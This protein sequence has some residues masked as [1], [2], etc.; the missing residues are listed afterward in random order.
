MDKLRKALNVRLSEKPSEPIEVKPSSN[1]NTFAAVV[2]DSTHHPQMSKSLEDVSS[3][4]LQSNMLHSFGSKVRSIS[5]DETDINTGKASGV[6]S[7]V[8]IEPELASLSNLDPRRKRASPRSRSNSLNAG[9][10]TGSYTGSGFSARISGK[11]R[12]IDECSEGSISPRALPSPYSAPE[13]VAEGSQA[14]SD[15]GF[16][17]LRAVAP[18]PSTA[19]FF[20]T[21]EE[22]NVHTAKKSNT[23]LDRGFSMPSSQ[24]SLPIY[25]QPESTSD[26]LDGICVESDE[27][28]ESRDIEREGIFESEGTPI[29]C[30][31]NVIAMYLIMCFHIC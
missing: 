14:E 16:D 12:S 10:P 1:K 13:S 3:P 17:A 7:P 20:E 9:I 26:K 11:R 2:L 27:V 5:V 31:Q 22:L 28:V 4:E 21:F 15:Y 6:E 29:L 25:S 18:S 8:D 23:S 19:K 30:F 24:E